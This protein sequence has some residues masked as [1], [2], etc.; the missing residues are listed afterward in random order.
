MMRYG[1]LVSLAGLWLGLV[2]CGA[3]EG[4]PQERPSV[5]D[6]AQVG[7]LP[8][9]SLGRADTVQL[10]PGIYQSG[11]PTQRFELSAMPDQWGRQRMSQW[12]WAASSQMVLNFHGVPVSQEDVVLRAYGGF[13]DRPAAS[14]EEIALAIHGWQ[15][16]DAF[17]QPRV[18]QAVP[19]TQMD[20]TELLQDLHF[21]QPVVMALRN[22]EGGGGHAYV[23]SSIT[24]QLDAQGWVYPIEVSLRD[25]WPENPGHITLPWDETLQRM[26]GYVRVRVL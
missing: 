12:C 2:A 3:E 10:A 13:L 22:R 24:Y 6:G 4:Q 1:L 11:V 21:N 14:T 20:V 16:V 26:I 8:A 23:L 17:G 18:V 9:D 7:T 25:P 15:V 5:E 19:F